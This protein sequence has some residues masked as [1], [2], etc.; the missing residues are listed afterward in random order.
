MLLLHRGAG[1]H[2]IVKICD[3]GRGGGSEK[4]KSV[5]TSLMDSPLL[6][7]FFREIDLSICPN[8]YDFFIIFENAIYRKIFES[9]LLSA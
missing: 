5:V 7:F 9:Y 3:Q 6:N 4:M 1:G 2:I 8:T